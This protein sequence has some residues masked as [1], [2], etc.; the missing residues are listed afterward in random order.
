M[1]QQLAQPGV[2]ERFVPEASAK[3]IRACF[4]GL[5]GLEHEDEQTRAVIADAIEK[6]GTYVL[7]PQ[8]EGGGNNMWG[9]E[10]VDKLST[11]STEERS[12]FILMQRIM[13]MTYK[14]ALMKNGVVSVVDCVHELGIYQTYL[15]NGKDTLLNEF[16][17]TL[18]RTKQF[19]VDE[20]GVA[21][22]Y[23]VVNSPYVI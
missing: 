3:R 21:S 5:W 22:G 14:A 6:P 20:G 1:Q 2:V 23:S 10:I 12:A 13:P 9:Q 7:K 15:G 11:A 18:L 4:A 16:C 19:G 8:R 17:G